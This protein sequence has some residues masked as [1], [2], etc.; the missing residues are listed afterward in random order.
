MPMPTLEIIK[1]E[2]DDSRIASLVV[3][4]PG[5][6]IDDFNAVQIVCSVAAFRREFGNCLQIRIRTTDGRW[7]YCVEGPGKP[8]IPMEHGDNVLAARLNMYNDYPW[9]QG[10]PRPD[11]VINVTQLKCAWYQRT[12]PA[13]YV[14]ERCLRVLLA[15]SGMITTCAAPTIKEELH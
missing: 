9:N 11:A 5:C 2:G 7:R 14:L 3:N 4:I 6:D 13:T 10:L 15:Y 8:W 1:A 12:W